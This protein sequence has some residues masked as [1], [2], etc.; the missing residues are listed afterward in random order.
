MECYSEWAGNENVAR[1]K[2]E[3]VHSCGICVCDGRERKRLRPNN[4]AHIFLFAKTHLFIFIKIETSNLRASSYSML[5]FFLRLFASLSAADPSCS[6]WPLIYVAIFGF[7][8]LRKTNAT[9][10][11]TCALFSRKMFGLNWYAE[12]VRD[13]GVVKVVLECAGH[14]RLFDFIEFNGLPLS[15]SCA[16]SVIIYEKATA[17]AERKS[18]RLFGEMSWI[19]SV[20]LLLRNPNR[21]PPHSPTLHQSTEM[22]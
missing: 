9:A 19:P 4:N 8:L 12:V 10:M 6:R 18:A 21:W 1:K 15:L 13:D 16:H 7:A 5:F 20:F 14:K 11:A 2:G 3:F 22:K 17:L